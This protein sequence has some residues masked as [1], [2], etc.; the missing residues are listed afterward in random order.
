LHGLI[1]GL[2][3]PRIEKAVI[4]SG[5]AGNSRN[6]FEGLVNHVVGAELPVDFDNI[7]FLLAVEGRRL[8]GYDILAKQTYQTTPWATDLEWALT[9]A[10][11][12]LNTKHVVE[13][14]K[15]LA[16]RLKGRENEKPKGNPGEQ[17]GEQGGE[18]GE[19]GQ[20]G[21]PGNEGGEQPGE[22]GEQGQPGEGKG[23]G[24]G[25]RQVV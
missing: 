4:R 6:L 15:E 23:K 11:T 3:D 24:E 9:E 14:A 1:N 10:H 20:P 16:Q 12:A 7:P 22:P 18:Q 25:Q 2:E 8:N 13:I 21:Q 17:P 5:F 19:Q